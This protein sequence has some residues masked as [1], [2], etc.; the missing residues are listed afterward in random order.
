M[1]GKSTHSRER[2]RKEKVGERRRRREKTNPVVVI[3]T[4]TRIG[5]PI[6]T[7]LFSASDPSSGLDEFTF[8]MKVK[9]GIAVLMLDG[10]RMTPK[11]I[12][13]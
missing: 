11:F 13:N 8:T 2:E 1:N 3:L 4:S 12:C 10:S 5:N 7:S 6:T 9:S